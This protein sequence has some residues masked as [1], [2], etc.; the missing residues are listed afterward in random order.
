LC[1][2]DLALMY[3][4]CSTCMGAYGRSLLLACKF[5]LVSSKGLIFVKRWK[6][7]RVEE[8]ADFINDPIVSE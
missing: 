6:C 5:S 1:V 4:S 3:E 7:Y 2:R 8:F